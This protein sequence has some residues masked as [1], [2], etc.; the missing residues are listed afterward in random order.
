MRLGQDDVTPTS[1]SSAPPPPQVQSTATGQHHSGP[2]PVPPKPS[3]MAQPPNQPVK[4]GSFFAPTSSFSGPT[5]ISPSS[6]SNPGNFRPAGSTGSRRKSGGGHVSRLVQ[7]VDMSGFDQAG[8]RNTEHATS[9]VREVAGQD[10]GWG[11]DSWGGN[12]FAQQVAA[13]YNGPSSSSTSRPVVSPHFPQDIEHAPSPSHIA[14]PPLPPIPAKEGDF[15]SHDPQQNSVDGLWTVPRILALPENAQGGVTGLWEQGVWDFALPDEGQGRGPVR[16]TPEGLKATGKAVYRTM[17]E[18]VDT[19]RG[20]EDEGEGAAAA[21]N[22]EDTT[23]Q[24]ES[25]VASEGDAV[26]GGKPLPVLDTTSLA[27][28]PPPSTDAPP[29]PSKATRPPAPPKPKPRPGFSTPT[30]SDLSTLTRP[31]PHLYFCPKT[32]SWALCAPLKPVAANTSTYGAAASPSSFDPELFTS[33]SIPPEEAEAFLSE[34]LSPPLSRP[35]AP[36]D[37]DSFSADYGTYTPWTPAR[38]GGLM[39]LVG[40]KGTRA[41]LSPTG[42]Y[43]SVIGRDLW[44]RL[45]KKRGEDPPPGTAAEEAKWGAIRALDN[46]LFVGETRSLPV[47]GKGFQ[48]AM[49]MDDPT[50]DLLLATLG[51]TAQGVAQRVLVPPVPDERTPEGRAQR[52][53]LVKAW[54]EI[55]CWME[56]QAFMDIGPGREAKRGVGETRVAWR[57]ARARLEIAL[58]GDQIPRIPASLAWQTVGQPFQL[59]TQQGKRDPN[60]GLDPCARDYSVLGL[61]PDVADEVV[62]K[63]YDLQWLGAEGKGPFFLEALTRIAQHRSSDTLQTK[64]VMEASRDR[65]SCSKIN[66][67]YSEL[68]LPPPFDTFSSIPTEDELLAAFESRNSAVEHPARRKILLEAAKVVAKWRG[69]ETLA[70]IIESLPAEQGDGSGVESREGMTD[71]TVVKAKMD[72]P[73]AFVTLGVEEGT[74]DEILLMVHPIRLDDA[75][76]DAEKEKVREALEVIAE[77]RNSDRLKAYLT[78]GSKDTWQSPH[79]NPDLPVGLTNI[80]NTC[81]L[82]SL[83]QYFFTVREL[84]ETILAFDASAESAE[85]MKEIR[86]GGR[87]VSEMEVKRS[88]RFVTLLQTLYTQ[89]LHSPVSVT[90]E[91]ELAYLALVPSKEEESFAQPSAASTTASTSKKVTELDL[92]NSTGDAAREEV[93]SLGGTTVLGKRKNGA[94]EA[95]VEEKLDEM[96][97]DSQPSTSASQ[98]PTPLLPP[99]AAASGDVAM[100]DMSVGEEGGAEEGERAK[101]R[102]RSLSQ[103]LSAEGEKASGSGAVPP[104]LP[105]RPAVENSTKGEGKEKD[106]MQGKVENYMAFGRQNDVTECMDNVMFQVETALLA[107][108]SSSPADGGRANLLKRTFYGS[109]L[110]TLTFSPPVPSSITD[111]VRTQNEPFS[112]L[113]VDVPPL[114]IPSNMSSPA[115]QKDLYDALDPVFSP[116]SVELDSHPASRRVDLLRENLPVL[117]QIQ[118]QRVQFD[119]ERGEVFK[120]NAWLRFAE[121]VDVR[122]FCKDDGEGEGSERKRRREKAEEIRA[123][124]ERARG[125][126]VE[127]VAGGRAGDSTTPA[128]S[129]PSLLRSTASHFASLAASSLTSSSSPSPSSLPS[130]LSSL[131]TSDLLTDTQTEADLLEAEIRAA[132]DEVKKGKEELEG[133]WSTNPEQEGEGPGVN[134]TETRYELCSVFIH[135]GTALSGHYYIL[136][137]DSRNPERWLKYNDSLITEVPKEDVFKETTG[138]ANPY[139]LVYVRRD[140]SDAIESIKREAAADEVGGW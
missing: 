1:T 64:L 75:T 3:S 9:S 107:S 112:S 111:P 67:A 49:P 24:S 16:P 102:G 126:V 129:A 103:P 120:S 133:L 117:L 11:D 43:P 36:A 59:P 105:P 88:K 32:F 38:A 87:L 57:D 82:N 65:Y 134:G 55:G 81:Y 124:V 94:E 58:G 139:F 31:H 30:F 125:R 33:N 108:S 90:P 95:G 130:S 44:E 15:F 77:A 70:A 41:V 78:E 74:D 136:Q 19:G 97:I 92:V 48:K 69:S 96:A 98:L 21:G 56:K 51:F 71:V 132:E 104:P 39:E 37:S 68:R 114:P 101:K 85:P 80:A 53:R 62:D 25:E 35:C 121:G 54:F 17:G 12:T 127:L 14:L 40:N 66:Q 5:P 13:T 131:L 135:R 42:W 27:S 116:S 28:A 118:L 52:T 73:R 138:D 47:D 119:R 34:H 60:T 115:L 128:M 99:P 20:T 113:L 109:T 79:V 140:R 7:D 106:E 4:A 89:L 123:R 26:D 100:E 63:V 22:G 10:G 29:S 83:L 61:T 23:M 122:R 72:L 45:L 50:H 93:K 86:V 46:L 84:R 91:T 18:F 8:T 110:Q 76:N 137:R 6:A 2:P